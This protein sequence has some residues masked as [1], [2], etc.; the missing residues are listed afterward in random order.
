GGDLLA[1]GHALEGAGALP[2]CAGG[3]QD[4]L[5]VLAVGEVGAHGGVGHGGVVEDADAAVVEAAVAAVAGG[6]RGRVVAFGVGAVAEDQVGHLPRA[7]FEREPGL[8]V[9]A[10]VGEQFRDLAG[11]A[12]AGRALGGADQDDADRRAD[13]DQKQ[14]QF[15]D[16]AVD[17]VVAG[18]QEL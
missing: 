13:L 2:V 17:V 8:V 1:G 9:V 4:L 12:Q 10:E 11:G 7:G 15:R 6:K 3:V 14:Q 18:G 5:G 16:F